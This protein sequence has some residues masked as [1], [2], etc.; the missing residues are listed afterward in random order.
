MHLAA[1]QAFP[2]D[3]NPEWIHFY[4]SG[5]EIHEYIKKTARKWNLDRDVRLN[6]KVTKAVWQEDLG[7]WKVTVACGGVGWDEYADVLISGQ[8]VLQ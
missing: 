6:T 2:F 8:G 3:P 1:E 7:N 4:S 5:Q